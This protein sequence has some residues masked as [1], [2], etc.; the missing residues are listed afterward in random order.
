[1][2]CIGE[3]L[4][5]LSFSN[6]L[7]DMYSIGDGLDLLRFYDK[8]KGLG[9]RPMS[10]GPTGRVPVFALACLRAKGTSTIKVQGSKVQG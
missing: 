8:F 9:L 7:L 10:Y 6:A 4:E 5:I 3:K 2:I 1:M